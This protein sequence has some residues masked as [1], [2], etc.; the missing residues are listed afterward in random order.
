M[1]VVKSD[2]L[3]IGGGVIGLMTARELANAGATVSIV[4]RGECGREASWAGGG[5]VSP[6]YPWRYCEAVTALAKQ[7]QQ[8]Y[9]VLVQSLLQETSID[10]EL[11]QTGL[12]MLDAED[13]T[14][15]L[16]WAQAYSSNMQALSTHEVYQRVPSLGAGF[17]HGLWMPEIANVRNPQLL[18]ALKASARLHA[19][20]RVI[21]NANV[22]GFD[23]CVQSEK[24][25]IT[26][27]R[28]ERDGRVSHLRADQFI[29]TAGAWSGQLLS[30]L[31]KNIAI[32]PVKGQMLLFNPPRRLLNAMVLTKG[33]YLIPRRD[34]HI[35]V[36]STLEFTEFDKTTSEE[37]LISLRQSAIELMP[38]LAHYPV[39]KQ[40][41]GLRP[42]TVNGVPYIGRV[43]HYNNLS[44]NSG[45]YRNGL[46]LAPASAKLLADLLLGRDPVVDPS[47]Y[48]TLSE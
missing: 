40:W 5:I 34:N 20:I 16:Q 6:L 39:I 45:Q 1:E 21:E 15:A 30:P 37:A 48:Q 47:P 25:T 7:A 18:K 23:V 44:V 17:N 26:G 31:A 33:R 41:A 10:P 35:L 22:Q 8:Y 42:G 9:P 46:V 38:E 43:D 24:S 19:N 14:D 36:G 11:E 32:T 12:L 28:I 13:A 29:V 3:V 4:E 2:F 27:A